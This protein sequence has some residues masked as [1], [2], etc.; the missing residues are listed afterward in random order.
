MIKSTLT[1]VL[2]I[3]G[4]VAFAQ[5]TLAEHSYE[6]EGITEVSVSGIFCDVTVRRSANSSMVFDGRIEGDGDPGDYVIA[7]IRSGSTVVFKVERK[8]GQNWG[9]SDI[10]LARLELSLPV[11][12][13]LKVDNTSG[14][15]EVSDYESASLLVTATSGDIILRGIKANTRLKTTSGDVDV[16]TAQGDISV[17]STSGDQE[18]NDVSGNLNSEAT[19]GDIEVRKFSGSLELS[20]TSGDIDLR[21]L[22]GLVSAATTSGDIK[23]DYIQL[24]GDSRFKSTSGDIIMDLENDLEDVGFDLRATSG[25]LEVGHRD[26]EDRLVIKRGNVLVTGISTSGDQRYD[27]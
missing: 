2:L 27:N 16:N 11:G 4:L 14:D 22:E 25:D 1:L 23:G 6:A 24:T 7:S 10:S 18:L 19:S 13:T 17:R 3:A 26:A 8:K 15:V 21:E 20:A 5:T 12:T 9:W